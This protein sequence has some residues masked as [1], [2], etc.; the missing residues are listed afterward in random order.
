MVIEEKFLGFFPTTLHYV[1]YGICSYKELYLQRTFQPIKIFDNTSMPLLLF[2]LAVNYLAWLLSANISQSRKEFLVN[3]VH[4]RAYPIQYYQ[5]NGVVFGITCRI[6]PW[7]WGRDQNYLEKIVKRSGI[8][9]QQDDW[10]DN[11]VLFVCETNSPNQAVGTSCRRINWRWGLYY[12][13]N[14]RQD[15]N[16]HRPGRKNSSSDASTPRVDNWRIKKQELVNNLVFRMMQMMTK[17]SK[18]KLE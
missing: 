3:K 18:V 13:E 9:T 7:R 5:A 16:T 6:R 4:V 14:I 15:S 12:T 17:K 8:N 2:S 11:N 10:D 1:P